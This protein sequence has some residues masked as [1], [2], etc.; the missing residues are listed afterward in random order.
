MKASHLISFFGGVLLTLGVT[1]V[2]RSQAQ[3]PGH[4]YELRMYHT[5]PGRL[6]ALQKRFRDHTDTIFARHNMKSIGYWIPQDTPE[7]LIYILQHP[8]REEGTKNWAAFMADPEWVKV[9]ADSEANGK[10]VDHVDDYYMTP[11][12]YSKLK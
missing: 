12:D 11:T 6:D 7:L 10:I 3:T 4:V 8:S 5:V 9:K 1:T 2:T